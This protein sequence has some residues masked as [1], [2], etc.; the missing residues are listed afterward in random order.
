[1]SDEASG[2]ALARQRIEEAVRSVLVDRGQMP[3]D[4]QSLSTTQSLYDAGLTSHATVK[5]MLALEDRFDVEFPDE[6]LQRSV[7]DQ[8]A[9]IVE[10]VDKLCRDEV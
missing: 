7:F 3:A 1:M 4:V 10:A 6:L 5:V 9:N 8:I 2:E